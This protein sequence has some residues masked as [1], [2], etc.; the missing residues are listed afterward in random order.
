MKSPGAAAMTRGMQAKTP[1]ATATTMGREQRCHGQW[2]QVSEVAEGTGDDEG[3]VNKGTMTRRRQA[4][5]PMLT[6]MPRAR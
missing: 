1:W 2:P 6:E 3:D 5:V 4:R